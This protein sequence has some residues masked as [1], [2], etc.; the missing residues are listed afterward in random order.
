MAVNVGVETLGAAV[1]LHQIHNADFSKCQ[2]GA[3][4]GVVG[5]IGKFIF[6]DFVHLIHGGMFSGFMQF[7]VD[8][9]SLGRHFEIVRF[10][11]IY[12]TLQ[13]RIGQFFLHIA[14]K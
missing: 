6:D 13:L 8:G 11:C 4:H 1:Y 7:A 9:H 3:A 12:E 2:H 10:A 5:N 14:L